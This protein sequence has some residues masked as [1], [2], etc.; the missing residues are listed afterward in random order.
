MG[1]RKSSL[2]ARALYEREVGRSEEEQAGMSKRRV[3]QR[4]KP[5]DPALAIWIRLGEGVPPEDEEADGLTPGERIMRAGNEWVR[6][7]L[8]PATPLRASAFAVNPFRRDR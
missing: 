5:V 1:D 2:S 4:E 8:R 6:E 7:Q 3:K